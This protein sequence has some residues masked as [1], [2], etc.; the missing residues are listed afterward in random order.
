[1]PR[2]K[3]PNN[4]NA[5]K[6][7]KLDPRINTWAQASA[8]IASSMFPGTAPGS[9]EIYP[10]VSGETSVHLKFNLVGCVHTEAKVEPAAPIPEDKGNDLEPGLGAQMLG[11]GIES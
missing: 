4:T 3:S 11:S 6:Q 1:M 7:L 2:K 10:L 8:S 5:P 9:F